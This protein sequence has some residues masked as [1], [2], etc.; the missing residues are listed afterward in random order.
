VHKDYFV[1]TNEARTMREFFIKL[2]R[3]K[4]IRIRRLVFKLERLN[5]KIMPGEAVALL[6]NNGSGK[7]TILLLM[8]G[9]YEPT[10]GTVQTAG[11]ISAV[12]ELGAGFHAELTG[13][14][15]VDLYGSIIGIRR[16]AMPAYR[17]RIVEFADL[18]EFLDLP[19]KFYSSGMVARLAFAVAVCVDPDVLLLDEVLAVGD[20][21]FR[22]K[23]FARL[24]Q[25]HQA[26]A[27]LLVAS[28]DLDVIK[29]LCT[30]A[31][32]LDHG[33]LLRDGPV[34]DV[35]REYAVSM[36][37]SGAPAA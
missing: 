30:R 34:D 2:A 23:C 35:I 31:I 21:A 3:L 10:T 16:D 18:A 32:L 27:T 24:H 1:Y 29:E 8:A 6:G 20:G 4:A 13:R 7:S 19:I 33:K 25:L 5:V 9:I 12:L 11:R 36:S 22:R 37:S 14:E 17:S 26:N 15:N 28:H